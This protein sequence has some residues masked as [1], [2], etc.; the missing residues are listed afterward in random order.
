MAKIYTKTGDS[1]TTALVGGTRVSKAALRVQCY[2][3]VD[4]L[5]AHAGLLRDQLESIGVENMILSIQEALFVLGAT[6]ACDPDKKSKIALPALKETQILDIEKQIDK[7][8]GELPKMTHFIL[9]GG[10]PFVSQAHITRC[11]C[12]RA[13]RECVELLIQMNP[14]VANPSKRAQKEEK[15]IDPLEISHKRIAKYLNRLSDYFFVLGRYISL[16]LDVP[17]IKWQP[18]AD[19]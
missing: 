16:K 13:E 10:H 9:P 18:S 7:M 17:E 4:E 3:T 1:G 11:V 6:L 5:N 15:S 12:R 8:D 2:G 19:K 14:A